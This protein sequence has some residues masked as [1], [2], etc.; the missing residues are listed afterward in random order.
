MLRAYRNEHSLEP[1]TQMVVMWTAGG[2][3]GVGSRSGGTR[4]D[5]GVGGNRWEPAAALAAVASG[6]GNGEW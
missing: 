1:H 3:S 2:G 6:K 4:I 5:G